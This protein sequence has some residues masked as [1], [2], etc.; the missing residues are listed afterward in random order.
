MQGLQ[1]VGRRAVAPASIKLTTTLCTREH[2]QR[3]QHWEPHGPGKAAVTLSI[4]P[5]KQYSTKSPFVQPGTR[6]CAS[7]SQAK[8]VHALKM[9]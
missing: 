1:Q 2:L 4:L 5:G 6:S 9:V 7:G 8:S 3:A